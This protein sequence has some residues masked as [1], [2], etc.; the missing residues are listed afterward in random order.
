M[1]QYSSHYV[2]YQQSRINEIKA[3]L[4]ELE[5]TQAVLWKSIHSEDPYQRGVHPFTELYHYCYWLLR[6][7]YQLWGNLLPVD[8]DSMKAFIAICDFCLAELQRSLYPLLNDYYY[9]QS[10]KSKSV[11]VNTSGTSSTAASS[12]MT[13]RQVV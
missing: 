6:S 5:Q 7:E 11:A 10:N 12:A 4:K 9:Q 2:I 13:I 1:S 8:V 3:D